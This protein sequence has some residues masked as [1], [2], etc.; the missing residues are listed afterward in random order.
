MS[1]EAVLLKCF[2]CNE[3]EPQDDLNWLDGKGN[4]SPRPFCDDC[5]PA[6]RK[7]WGNW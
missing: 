7:G 1:D 6:A 5:E 2:S 4:R 3:E